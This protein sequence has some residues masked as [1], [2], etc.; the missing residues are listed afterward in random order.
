MK[1]EMKQSALIKDNFSQKEICFTVFMAMFWSKSILLQFVRVGLMKI[2]VIWVHGD[3]LITAGFILFFCLSFASIYKELYIKD[4]FIIFS[5]YAIFLL[6]YCLFPLNRE[7]YVKY[8]STVLQDVLPKF[9]IGVFAFRIHREQTLK[10]LNLISVI[11]VWF[12][13]GYMIV[14]YTMEGNTLQGGDMH[15]A[16]M[17]LPHVCMTFYSM[18]R[19]ANLW[20]LAGVII[21]AVCLLFLGNRGSLLCLGMFSVFTILFSGRLKRPLLFMILSIIVLVAL[22]S[23]GILDFLYEFAEEKGF[24]LRIFEKLESGDITYASGRDK[25]SQRIMEYISLYPMMGMGIFSDRRVAGGLYAHNFFLE[26]AI[27]FGLILGSLF[28]LIILALFIV[29]FLYLRKKEALSVGFYS[30]LIFSFFVKLLLSSSYIVEP[31]FFFTVG[32][33][34]AATSEWRKMRR[35]KGQ[36]YVKRNMLLK[37]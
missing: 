11:T 31:Y 25:L 34:Y 35:Q 32:Y 18:I 9:F 36:G 1:M 16:Y 12:Y 5:F 24:S 17:L 10:V 30:V 28:I 19:K 14:Y 22:F 27:H 6:H 29:A 3:L 23:F 4:L 13:A 26:I 37:G 8:G 21:G 20:N 15:A 33:A 2:P 7:Y